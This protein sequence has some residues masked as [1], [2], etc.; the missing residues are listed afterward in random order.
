MTD[1]A[2]PLSRFKVLDLTRARS[3]IATINTPDGDI[4]VVGS[5]IKFTGYNTSYL[6]PPLL[7]EHN[8]ELLAQEDVK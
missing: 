3:M 6:A 7:G 2:L 5:P 4:R 8:E 1:T